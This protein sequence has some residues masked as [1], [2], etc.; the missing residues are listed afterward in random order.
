MGCHRLLRQCL[1]AFCSIGIPQ[2]GLLSQ[3]SS[4]RLPLGHS[5]LVLIL[6]NAACTSLSSPRLLVADASVRDASPLGVAVRHVSVDFNYLLIF[7]PGYV[8]L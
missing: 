5:I 7:P 2:S 6:S 1:R 8:A 3:V 4:L